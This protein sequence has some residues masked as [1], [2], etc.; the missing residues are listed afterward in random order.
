MGVLGLNPFLQ[1]ICPD[2]FRAVP[3]RFRSLEGKRIVFD[4]TLITQRLHFAQVPHPFRHV[5]GWY[6]ILQELKESS[7][8]AVCVFDG[9]RRNI[10][11][12]NEVERRRETRKA[13]ISRGL[14]EKRRLERLQ[15]LVPLVKAMSHL[16]LETR[17][18]ILD[19]AISSLDIPTHTGI[20]SLLIDQPQSPMF[21]PRTHMKG[22]VPQPAD[23]YWQEADLLELTRSGLGMTVQSVPEGA[24][25][26][27]MSETLV[28]VP[29]EMPESFDDATSTPVVDSSIYSDI[30]DSK[31]IGEMHELIDEIAE[32]FHEPAPEQ[33][34]AEMGLEEIKATLSASYS[35][36]KVATEKL[37]S[38]P[39]SDPDSSQPRS[40]KD[41]TTEIRA[42][43]LISKAQLE[44]TLD[45]EILWH[46]L[47][48]PGSSARETV[49]E[50]ATTLIERS[51]ILSESYDRRTQ[52]PTSATYEES[53][54]IIRAMG[55]AC[56]E[57]EGPYEAE[58]VAASMVLQGHADYVASEDTDVLVYGAPLVRNV[59]PTTEPLIIIAGSDVWTKLNLNQESFI[60]FALLLGTDFTQRIRNI[61]P[62]RALK[63]IREYGNI[64]Q[65]IEH[66]KRCPSQLSITSYMEQITTARR[67]F[68]TLPPVPDE[69]LLQQPADETAIWHAMHKY[70]LW[71]ALS[72]EQSLGSAET[73]EGNYFNDNPFA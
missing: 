33:K 41:G 51:S 11:K 71:R 23:D 3:D 52:V 57:T 55:V 18:T 9:K 66:E 12:Q 67:V 25:S 42:E 37:K 65:I 69:E 6:R 14:L 20:P 48:S 43:Q 58:A 19:E 28:E 64:E 53:K 35:E 4:G 27:S 46:E 73:L 2:V 29:F 17:S 63:L 5:L 7:V 26:S 21:L 62:T 49:E 59:T 54:E 22:G 10:A 13:A 47:L 36:Y 24:T 39:P 30:V 32:D 56:V 38:I 34:T 70:R 50:H 72:S 60:D 68:R 40:V 8:H 1:K 44:L 61:G 31:E 45:E 15:K 16:D